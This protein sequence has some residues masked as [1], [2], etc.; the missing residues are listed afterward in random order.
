METVTDK[1]SRALPTSSIST[2]KEYFA[3][4]YK[5]GGRTVYSL[6]QSPTQVTG[7][8]KRPDPS[9]SNPGNRRIRPDHASAFARY[10][11][12]NDNWVIPGIILRAPSIFSFQEDAD[13]VGFQTGVMRYAERNQGDIQIL[14]GQHRIL[15]FHMAHDMLD[16]RMDKARSAR[17]TA[18][19]VQDENA[20]KAAEAE[21]R[22]LDAV[23][24]RLATE[25]F[26]V[27]IHVTDDLQAYRQM[28]F[29][30]AE[31]ALGITASVKARFDARKV[32]NRALPTVLEQSLLEGRV[33]LEADRIPPTSTYFLA[34][35]HVMETLRVLTVGYD[36]R[37]S[38]RMD[39]EMSEVEIARRGVEFFDGLVAAFPVLTTL[40]AGQITPEQIRKSSLMGSPAFIRVLA[41]VFYELTTNHSY[42]PSMVFEF[43]SR[44]AKHTNASAHAN[45]IW[46]KHAAPEAF[47]EGAWGPNQRRQ[48]AKGLVMTI[49]DWAIDKEPFVDAEPESAPAIVEEEIDEDALIDFA[50]GHNT[51]AL[52]VELRN[53]A[54][55]IATA[56]KA[57]AKAQTAS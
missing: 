11:I 18:R 48:D 33:D 16:A 40:K 25:R 19:R 26:T 22:Q 54:E 6:A 13:A 37:V 46:R 27:E 34:A 51:K 23:R 38:K 12:D 42:T 52:D 9:A 28:F 15:G 49:A 14:D 2:D 47:H 50:M 43:F 24:E 32:V 30:I 5:Q 21:I 8:V 3:T 7:L 41:G 45:S 29:D 55:E 31:N 36:G 56:S 39:K 53:E 1:A 57:R 44:L 10:L 4:R 20:I 17:A 35:R